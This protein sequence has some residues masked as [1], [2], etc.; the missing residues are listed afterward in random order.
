MRDVRPDWF[1]ALRPSWLE[2][3]EKVGEDVVPGSDCSTCRSCI[4][5]PGAHPSPIRLT[6]EELH[7][8][9][10]GSERRRPGIEQPFDVGRP[11]ALGPPVR[12]GRGCESGGVTA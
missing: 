7:S 1:F 2:L 5:S 11:P 6:S 12:V 10:S 8:L 3:L 9:F 4:S